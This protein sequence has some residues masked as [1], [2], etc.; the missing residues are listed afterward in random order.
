MLGDTSL[1]MFFAC[2]VEKDV[3][4]NFIV[5]AIKIYTK[6]ISIMTPSDLDIIR[7]LGFE[8][9]IANLVKTSSSMYN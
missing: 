1:F 9:R 3:V 7:L 2:N 4:I 5:V 6:C 8:I